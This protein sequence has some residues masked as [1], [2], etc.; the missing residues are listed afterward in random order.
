MTNE[1]KQE[2]TLRIS[3]ANKTQLIVILYDITLTYLK[4]ALTF[5]EQGKTD[6]Y[7]YQLQLAKKCIEEMIKNLHFEYALAA[8]L[9]QIYLSMKKAL[10]EA[11]LESR[12][13]PVKAVMTNIETL[14]AA[15][16][17]IAANDTSEPVMGHTQTVVA[18]LTYGKNSLSED[19]SG[20]SS[21]RGFRV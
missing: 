10:R 18:G 7:K 3:Q 12:D 1:L 19:L 20:E 5:F 6:E 21:N 16:E 11:E 2:Y 4:D 13:E 14:K 8:D 15:Y 9:K 17:E